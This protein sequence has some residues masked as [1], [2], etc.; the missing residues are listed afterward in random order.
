VFRSTG[1]F[2]GPLLEDLAGL[3]RDYIYFH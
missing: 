2:L 3:K 1:P